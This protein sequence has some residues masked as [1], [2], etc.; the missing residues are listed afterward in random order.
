MP[1]GGARAMTPGR[2][3]SE[4]E[5]LRSEPRA[6]IDGTV[7]RSGVLPREYEQIGIFA[8]IFART[9][10]F[11]RIFVSSFIQFPHP[12]RRYQG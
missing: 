12:R 4:A 8:L 6:K 3:A 7:L 5:G 1:A 10:I 11:A 2:A 9:C